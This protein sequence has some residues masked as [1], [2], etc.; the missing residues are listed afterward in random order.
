MIVDAHYHLDERIEPVDALL[1]RMDRHGIGRTALIPTMVDPIRVGRLAERSS[2]V[3][4]K[5]LMS[6]WRGLG[7]RLYNRTVTADGRFVLLG[8]AY[9][10][11][12]APR[13]ENVASAMQAHPDRF[14][15]WIFVNPTTA[16]A[17]GEPARWV[18][19]SGWIGVKCHPF[20]HRYPVSML[21]D[22]A[23]YCVEKDLPLLMHLGGDRERGDYRYLPE[24]HP[25]LKIVYAHAGIPFYE[26]LW[27]YASSKDNVL[28][29]LSNPAFVDGR[30]ARGAINALGV[31]KCLYGTD[32]PYGQTNHSGL[33]RE[34]LQMPLSDRDKERILADNFRELVNA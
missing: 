26:E 24:R 7:L 10:I 4:R 31:E 5:L 1:A 28:V 13:N 29:D 33:L 19:R 16:D 11:Y 3:L 14:H 9:R 6:R 18:G 23:A 22:V 8:K 12:D 15:G 27:D 21:D 2:V 34:I 17:L 25:E 20:W 30:I 32:G